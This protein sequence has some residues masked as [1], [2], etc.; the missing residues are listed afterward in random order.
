M[1]L[2]WSILQQ[3]PGGYWPLAP[4]IT[5]TLESFA[6]DI[7]DVL[8]VRFGSSLVA[9]QKHH[10]YYCFPTR[11]WVG[12]QKHVFQQQLSDPG[13]MTGI[14]HKF[15]LLAPRF[16]RLSE[17]MS[18]QP[19]PDLS[20]EELWNLYRS[21]RAEFKRGYV[22]GEP[23]AFVLKD[24]LSE[25]LEVQLA[26]H[27][28]G[29]KR[30]AI[31]KAFSLLVAPKEKPFA[32]RQEEDFLRIV[33]LAEEGK[34]VEEELAR[35]TQTFS[36]V[37]FDYGNEVWDETHFRSQ[38]KELKSQRFDAEKRLKTI[39]AYYA[40]LERRQG[41]LFSRLGLDEGLR[42][43][44][45]ALQVC[46]YLIDHKKE[47][48]TRGNLLFEP[49]MREIARR[50]GVARRLF[51]YAVDNEVEAF[52][53][54]GTRV[55]SRRLSARPLGC[56]YVCTGA[57]NLLYEGSEATSFLDRAG[58][59][60]KKASQFAEVKGLCGCAGAVTGKARVLL[61]AGGIGKLAKGE[62][63]VTM[64][65]T[66]DFIAGMKRAAAVVTNEGGITSHAAIVSRE[67]GIPCVVGTGN[68]TKV[69]KTGDVLEVKASHG[70]VRKL[71]VKGKN[72]KPR[73]K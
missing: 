52:L 46:S 18:T 22:Y 70:V 25:Y 44:F 4:A 57:G 1:N 55:D 12:V 7:Q 10:Q 39:H 71:E 19:L 40:N 48:Y 13:L 62:I 42:D 11:E 5:A 68:A 23:P 20:N 2:D 15:E 38:L 29:E 72:A 32:T 36:W 63:L 21:W 43:L 54:R 3:R 59:S 49:V 27:L 31:G 69:F 65:T 28:P 14:R 24:V 37:P 35:H 47:V 16:L 56:A 9:M 34:D 61:S 26:K 33:V 17:A 6:W 50:A 64:M 73:N 41:E 51:R 60:A 45:K 53:K 58:L 67:L 30:Q 66:P 8:G